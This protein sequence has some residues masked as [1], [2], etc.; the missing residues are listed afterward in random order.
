MQKDFR[1]LLPCFGSFPAAFECAENLPNTKIFSQ[2]KTEKDLSFSVL[3]ENDKEIKLLFSIHLCRYSN[4]S[5]RKLCEP[6][7]THRISDISPERG[8]SASK[9]WNVSYSVLRWIIFSLVPPLSAPPYIFRLIY[10]L[11]QNR[12][13][14]VCL[15][16]NTL[17][18]PLIP[19]LSALRAQAL[20]I[21]RT[22]KSGGQLQQNILPQQR[23]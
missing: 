19:V 18:H 6:V 8:R 16:G 9:R 23:I 15:P 11:F 2:E 13:T 14:R 3:C 1:C 7:C 22:Q 10:Q 5:C 20:A 12:Q 21:R 4:R 17:A